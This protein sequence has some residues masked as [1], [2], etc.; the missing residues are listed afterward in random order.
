MNGE[1][2]YSRARSRNMS[3]PIWCCICQ[4][5]PQTQGWPGD[6]GL[7]E[8]LGSQLRKC[9]KIWYV[10]IYYNLLHISRF[11]WMLS[12]EG[13][14]NLSGH[15][16]FGWFPVTQICL[17]GRPS[18]FFKG[19]GIERSP[20]IYP[21]VIYHSHGKSPFL[22]GKPSINGPFSMAMLNNQRVIVLVSGCQTCWK[23]V[24]VTPQPTHP[25]S[26][27]M[28]PLKHH[29]RVGDGKGAHISSGPFVV[30]MLLQK[31]LVTGRCWILLNP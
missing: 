13:G 7:Q 6:P 10:L 17:W 29:L 3:N 26:C 28:S 30:G 16:G 23:T 18:D 22:I 2:S 1:C 19:R 9:M 20:Q 12:G 11:L 21:L 27:L 31:P 24:K 14:E 8:V 15:V 5:C 25:T 4:N